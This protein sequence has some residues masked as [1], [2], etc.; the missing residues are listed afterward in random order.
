LFLR[1]LSDQIDEA[2]LEQ[3][4]K[5][6]SPNCQILAIR[7]IRDESG[8]KRGIAFIDVASQ[9]M[10]ERALKI[11]NHHLKGSMV[12]I[13]I[14]KPPALND[15]DDRT[16]FVNNLPRDCNE[17]DIRQLFGSETID[18]VRLIRDQGGKLKGFCYVQFYEA[19]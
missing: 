2:D 18:E 4:F 16:A 10:A 11:N 6:L 12:Q 13:F 7:L 15:A 8:I 14:S 9:E 3:L 1:N 17:E 19:E 5:D